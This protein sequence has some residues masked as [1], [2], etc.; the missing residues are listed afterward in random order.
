MSQQ[1][2]SHTK[3]TGKAAPLRIYRI[4]EGLT[5]VNLARMAGVDPVTIHR[6]E[7]GCRPSTKSANAIAHVLGRPV[8]AIFPPEESS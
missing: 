2:V 7:N 3:R 8:E 4:A 5:Q 1:K 6:L